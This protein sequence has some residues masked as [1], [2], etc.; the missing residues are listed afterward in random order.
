M[1][2][3]PPEADQITQIIFGVHI[4]E[5]RWSFAHAAVGDSSH[6]EAGFSK[7]FPG[8]YR[9]EPGEKANRRF[10]VTGPQSGLTLA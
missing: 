1:K 9:V 7:L 10:D 4:S 3:S 8:S 5:P 2:F 6:F